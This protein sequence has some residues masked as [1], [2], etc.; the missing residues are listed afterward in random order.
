MVIINFVDILAKL[1]SLAILVRVL[2]S[3]LPID[4]SGRLAEIILQITEPIVAPIRSVLPSFGGL[5]FSPMVA[6]LLLEMVRSVVIQLL[7]R[8]MM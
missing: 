1:L 5:D 6:L 7:W 2:L 8:V 4:R 3:W